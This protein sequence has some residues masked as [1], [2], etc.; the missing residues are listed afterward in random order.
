MTQEEWF[1][2]QRTKG[3][4]LAFERC[5]VPSYYHG[6]MYLYQ[7]ED[8]VP[9]TIV[10]LTKSNMV[11]VIRD[12]EKNVVAVSYKDVDLA[13]WIP[14]ICDCDLDAK[15]DC[16]LCTC[17]QAGYWDVLEENNER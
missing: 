12:G 16:D 14:D 15:D 9:A 2:F 17:G 5:L 4:S 3:T 8:Y 13:Q 10:R 6:A 7:K 1:E 11:G